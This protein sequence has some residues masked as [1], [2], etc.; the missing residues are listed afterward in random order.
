[1]TVNIPF[2]EIPDTVEA[3]SCT[4]LQPIHVLQIF[5]EMVSVP[6]TLVFVKEKFC[7]Q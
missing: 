2:H 4:P 1:M 5:L 6:H 7:D 3:Y